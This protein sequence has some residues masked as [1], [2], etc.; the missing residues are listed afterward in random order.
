MRINLNTI[1]LVNELVHP[2]PCLEQEARVRKKYHEKPIR[3][4]PNVF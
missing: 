3:K 1:A 2:E 4:N